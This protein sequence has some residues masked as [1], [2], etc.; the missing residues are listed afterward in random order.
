[1]VDAAIMRRKSQMFLTNISPVYDT[2]D[3][4]I[5]KKLKRG[6][7]P[8]TKTGIIKMISLSLQIG[9][10][11]GW[12]V[13]DK[14]CDNLGISYSNLGSTCMGFAIQLLLFLW[15]SFGKTV[16][17]PGFWIN[18]DIAVNMVISLVTILTSI[19][20]IK[21]C[22]VTDVQH[23]T[24]AL[25][26]AGACVSVCGCAALF[27]MYRFIEEPDPEQAAPKSIRP[28]PRKSLFA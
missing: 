25:S 27:L 3:E 21:I 18:L 13:L 11:A 9:S 20:S 26:T 12:A 1:M 7:F 14:N 4:V 15:F 22:K 19:I 24:A 17:D 28:D 10:I 23:L 8:P 2:H 6:K 16:K 5:R